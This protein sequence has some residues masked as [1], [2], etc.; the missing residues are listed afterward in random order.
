M[1]AEEIL[2]SSDEHDSSDDDPASDMSGSM[3]E[4]GG[5]FD[6]AGSLKLTN[7]KRVSKLEAPETSEM[8]GYLVKKSGAF[9][10]HLRRFFVLREGTLLWYESEAK[11][12]CAPLGAERTHLCKFAPDPKTP[13][14]FTLSSP[15]K[16][17]TLRADTPAD[18]VAWLVAL[19]EHAALQVEE[20]REPTLRRESA[21]RKPGGITKLAHRAE[22]RIA[23]RAVASD[24]GRRLLRQHCPPEGIML[25][26]AL[27]EMVRRH[28]IAS[29]PA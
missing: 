4:D 11:V 8:S 12:G 17:Y 15:V 21:E 10:R 13:E 5:M 9:S 25:L 18:A 26:E 27:R 23:E 16:L 2:M 19:R 22:R 28:R 29:R 14:G 3:F 1:A 24:V 7:P 20:G 6:A